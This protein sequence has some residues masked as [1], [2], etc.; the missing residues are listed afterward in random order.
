[1]PAER[2]IV[3]YPTAIGLAYLQRYHGY[4][5]DL[6]LSILKAERAA[7]MDWLVDDEGSRWRLKEPTT[8]IYAFEQ[9]MSKP[10]TRDDYMWEMDSQDISGV[11]SSRLWSQAKK[12]RFINTDP[13]EN[14]YN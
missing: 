13:T 9:L 5:P 12:F 10:W 14:P 2:D 3:Y 4:G 6:H 11:I 8:Y 1:M 7:G